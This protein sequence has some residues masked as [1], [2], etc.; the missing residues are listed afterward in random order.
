MKTD[1]V[2]KLPLFYTQVIGSLPRPQVVLNLLSRRETLPPADYR[3]RMDEMVVFAIRLQELAGLD[4]VSDGEWR[5][6]Q[7]TGEFL[8]RIGGFA[9]ARPFE[10]AGERKM[11]LVATERIQA[12]EPVFAD[13][14]AFLR[15][16]TDRLTKFALPS[17]FL[18]GIR[19]W[20]EDH[21]KEA[22]PT[23]Q[24]LMEHLADVL[25]REARALADAGIDIIQLD[26]PALTYFCDRALMARGETHDDRLRQGWDMD[27]QM[28]EA[29][30]L[31]NRIVGDLPVMTHLHCCHSVYKRSSDVSGDYKPILPHLA[32]AK[33]D[34]VNLEFAY[35]GTGD[36][37]D[38]DLLP[39]HLDVGMGVVDVRGERVQS[40]EEIQAIAAAGAER[41]D[42]RRIALNPDCGFAPDSGEPPTIDE[43]F[44]KLCNL[45]AAAGRLREEFST[46]DSAAQARR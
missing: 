11:H 34:Q 21:S 39:D 16:H 25:A 23:V 17:P 2:G 9:P 40:V 15:A 36:V 3:A 35:Q 30:G 29:I 27:R 14:A 18:V 43:A 28:P 46:K 44:E 20:H 8:D 5:R 7:Y 22:Y 33:I 38:L 1:A 10:H 19:Y 6:V 12:T 41:I 45:T 4:V 32:G 31:I 24:H 42:P 37:S 13:D 26:D